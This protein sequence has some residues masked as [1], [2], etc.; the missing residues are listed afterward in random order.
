MTGNPVAAGLE[1]QGPLRCVLKAKLRYQVEQGC[2]RFSRPRL[3]LYSQRIPQGSSEAAAA[4][5]EGTW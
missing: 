3:L 1:S 5:K 2:V 4:V